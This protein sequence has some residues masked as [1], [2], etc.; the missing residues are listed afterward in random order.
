MTDVTFGDEGTEVNPRPNHYYFNFGI[1]RAS[2]R[3]WTDNHY[4]FDIETK[5]NDAYTYYSN[6]SADTGY[7]AYSLDDAI[8][9]CLWKGDQGKYYPEVLLL[10]KTVSNIEINEALNRKKKKKSFF[11]SWNYSYKNLDG[12]T[13]IRLVWNVYGKGG[14]GN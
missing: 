11:I 7:A 5:T 12:N 8:Q 2:D 4:F 10:N 9:Y 6:R 14:A 13:V 1:D 3:T